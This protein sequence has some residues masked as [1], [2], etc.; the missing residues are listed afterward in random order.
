MSIDDLIKLF[1]ETE[2]TPEYQFEEAV[3]DIT[4]EISE[5]MEAKGITRADL[6]RQLGKSRAW[7]TKALNG[8][9]NMTLKTVVEILWTL[10]YKLKISTEQ[11]W[12]SNAVWKPVENTL[13]AESVIRIYP[14]KTS[15]KNVEKYYRESI[16]QAVED[17]DERIVAA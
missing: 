7:V 2:Q 3:V 17:V 15:K 4:E 5:I 16:E 1:E 9:Q 14:A 8:S 13:S 6:A 12:S 11:V 10:G